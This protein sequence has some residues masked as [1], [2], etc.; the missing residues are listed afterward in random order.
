MD[1]NHKLIFRYDNAPHHRDV[2]TF[3]HHK[4]ELE[5][6]K[7]ASE[8]GLKDVLLEIARLERKKK[9]VSS[10]RLGKGDSDP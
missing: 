8:P 9:R 4:H 6:V 3:P 1:D 5:D 7:G 2:H 10:E